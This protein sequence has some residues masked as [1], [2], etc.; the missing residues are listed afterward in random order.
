MRVIK[1]LRNGVVAD[2]DG[3]NDNSDTTRLGAS[4]PQ[5]ATGYTRL[6]GREMR[7][8]I[9]TPAA[10]RQAALDALNDYLKTSAPLFTG[11]RRSTIRTY[12]IYFSEGGIGITPLKELFRAATEL[13]LPDSGYLD[14]REVST[15]DEF[16]GGGVPRTRKR[17]FWG[18]ENR[19]NW[20]QDNDRD[21]DILYGEEI[22]LEEHA[23]G[24]M[25][26]KG[27]PRGNIIALLFFHFC[28]ENAA[29]LLDASM[30]PVLFGRF[31]E[32]AN[33]T[34]VDECGMMPLHPRKPF[35]RLFLAALASSAPE[36]PIDYL[37]R[38]L[39]QFYSRGY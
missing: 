23:V 14:M 21:W 2:N 25:L 4:Q 29:E 1:G 9:E 7:Q 28:Y 20:L 35:D 26:D 38:I 12:N 18:T 32:A 19:S 11:I 6:L 30:R 5:N 17:L 39:M 10:N 34:L 27:I 15:A 13:T 22:K 3:D 33:L 16:I 36:Q 24:E 37:N 8:M 31:Y